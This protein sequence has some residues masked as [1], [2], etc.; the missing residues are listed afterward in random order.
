M[1]WNYHQA[2]GVL[3]HDGVIVGVGY[4]GSPVSRNNPAMQNVRDVGPIP[5]G[6]YSIG[7]AFTHP[8]KGPLVMRLTPD[9]AN[10][11][12]GR[13]G[14]ELH[15]DSIAEP[16]TA[17]EGCMVQAHEVREAVALSTDKRLTVTP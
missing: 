13:A 3:D 5:C 4:S 2:S 11:M 10:E 14:F 17:S 6:E 1:S 15:G 8:E 12:F 16:G 9:P 7:Q